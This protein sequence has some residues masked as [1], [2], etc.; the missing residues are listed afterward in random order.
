MF[1][2]SYQYFFLLSF[3]I[4][5]TLAD[6]VEPSA[7]VI[8]SSTLHNFKNAL[9]TCSFRRTHISLILISGLNVAYTFLKSLPNSPSSID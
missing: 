1:Y 4:T 6:L 3:A 5:D 2:R 8:N 9:F 7:P